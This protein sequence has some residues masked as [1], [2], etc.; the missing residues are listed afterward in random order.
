M[1]ADLSVWE[2]NSDQGG[3]IEQKQTIAKTDFRKISMLHENQAPSAAPAEAV[4]GKWWGPVTQN[5]QEGYL[6]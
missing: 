1:Q 4:L 5:K 6:L 2:N 3:T